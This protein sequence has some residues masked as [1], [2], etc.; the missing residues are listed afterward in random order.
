MT[1]ENL[2][3]DAEGAI[4]FLGKRPARKESEEQASC[5][6]PSPSASPGRTPGFPRG[7][8]EKRTRR[9]NYSRKTPDTRACG[10]DRRKAYGAS[11]DQES[12]LQER[13]CPV[14]AED[15][16]AEFLRGTVRHRGELGQIGLADLGNREHLHEVKEQEVMLI[17]AALGPGEELRAVCGL[18]R[19][20]YHGDEC[21]SC[22]AER[23]EATRV[24]EN[25]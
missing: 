7:F 10:H 3:A 12:Y 4:A 5:P 21:P 20:P 1:W 2:S 11:K 17:S 19:T 13:D 15:I 23:E 16:G 8:G 6:L 25:T 14:A 22:R 18:R 9:C 24:I